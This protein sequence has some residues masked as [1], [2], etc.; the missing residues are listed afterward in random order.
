MAVAPLLARAR[1]NRG[2]PPAIV[3]APKSPT[4]ET[5]IGGNTSIMAAK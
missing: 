4:E 1:R 3:G 2:L 5:R